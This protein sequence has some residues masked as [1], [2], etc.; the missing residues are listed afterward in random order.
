MHEEDEK[1]TKELEERR[2]GMQARAQVQEEENRSE[3]PEAEEMLV[4]EDAHESLCQASGRLS[5]STSYVL[6]KTDTEDF[7]GQEPAAR[8]SSVPTRIYRPILW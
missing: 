1:R 3:K 2:G 6:I 7:L 8:P 4:E 5:V